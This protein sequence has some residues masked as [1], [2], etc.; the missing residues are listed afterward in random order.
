[1][2]ADTTFELEP[3]AG[4][5]RRRRFTREEYEWLVAKGVL[6]SDERLELIGGEIVERMT[7]QNSPHVAG[8][9]LSEE[10]LRKAFGAGYVV[11]VQAPLALGDDSE[12]EPE[13]AVVRGSIRDYIAMHPSTAALVVEVSDST[14]IADRGFKKGL[15]ARAGIQEYWVLNVRDRLLEVYREP[16]PEPGTPF[17]HG[18]AQATKLGG[19]EDVC[20][21]A[22][23]TPAR[24]RVADLLP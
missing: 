9:G 16:R 10:A 23:P 18:Y 6:R 2:D 14:L 22:A 24:I 21:L 4:P 5:F 3:G 17:G 12:P 15:Y 20:P 13:L 19:Q 7:P 11:R 1:M 8:I